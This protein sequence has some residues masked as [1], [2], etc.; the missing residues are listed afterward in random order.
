MT[1]IMQNYYL[2]NKEEIMTAE[3][4]KLK[5]AMLLNNWDIDRSFHPEDIGFLKTFADIVNEGQAPESVDY[6]YIKA[7]LF[8][9]DACITGWSTPRLNKVI[10]EQSPGLKLI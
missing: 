10:L 6:E 3:R 4:K 7:S 8:G 2:I 1:L 9:A 5:V